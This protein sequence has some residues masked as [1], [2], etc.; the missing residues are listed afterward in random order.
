MKFLDGATEATVAISD[1]CS[2]VDDFALE[3]LAEGA[4]TP[5]IVDSDHISIEFIETFNKRRRKQCVSSDRH[6]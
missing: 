6:A 2:H 5:H 1:V 4:Q 3:A